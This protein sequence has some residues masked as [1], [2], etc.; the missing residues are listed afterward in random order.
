V[1]QMT[2]DSDALKVTENNGIILADEFADEF[3][4]R[5]ETFYRQLFAAWEDWN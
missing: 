2:T 4:Q 3:I 1:K 5:I